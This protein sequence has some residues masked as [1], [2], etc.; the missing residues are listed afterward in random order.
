M[1]VL[2]AIVAI[3]IV[4]GSLAADFYWRRWMALRRQ[5]RERDRRL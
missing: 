4:A 5:E 1:K 2:L 3:V